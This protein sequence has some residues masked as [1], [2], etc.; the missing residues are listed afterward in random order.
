MNLEPLGGAE[1]SGLQCENHA[2]MLPRTQSEETE[3]CAHTRGRLLC[4]QREGEMRSSY[5][6]CSAVIFSLPAFH[7]IMCMH[8]LSWTKGSLP[9]AQPCGKQVDRAAAG[10]SGAQQFGPFR[11]RTGCLLPATHLHMHLEHLEGARQPA[12]LLHTDTT[13]CPLPWP[14]LWHPLPGFAPTELLSL[15]CH[16]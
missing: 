7:P 10:L 2:R 6:P 15:P 4:T 3:Q 11:D 8:I 13:C 16:H 12:C 5:V 9:M 14:P 1:S